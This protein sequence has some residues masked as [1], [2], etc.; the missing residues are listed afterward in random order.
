MSEG[1]DAVKKIT[2]FSRQAHSLS[3]QSNPAYSSSFKWALKWIPG[4]MRG[5]RGILYWRQEKTFSGFHI[6]SGEKDRAQW[7]REAEAYARKA[8][9]AKYVDALVPKTVIG[10]KRHVN[11]T[12]HLEALHRDNVELVHDD[13]ID[14]ILE[15]GV[16]TK[17]SRTV[18]ADP[19]ILGTGFETQ[20]PLHPS[21]IQGVSGVTLAEHVSF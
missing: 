11:D 19:L 8:A 17:S 3:E 15:H 16:A 5:H 18:R 14:H 13:P 1:K 12:F 4:F 2:R 20:R 10:C 6:L 21:D 7:A 9:P